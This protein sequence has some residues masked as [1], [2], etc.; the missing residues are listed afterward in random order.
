MSKQWSRHG[1]TRFN[2]YAS[3]YALIPAKWRENERWIEVSNN[4]FIESLIPRSA[5]RVGI[6]VHR[7]EMLGYGLARTQDGKWYRVAFSPD[8]RMPCLSL[9]DVADLSSIDKRFLTKEAVAILDEYFLAKECN[10]I[11]RLYRAAKKR[12]LARIQ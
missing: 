11:R 5:W 10:K 8:V 3:S 4:D 7:D 12:T 1:L 2:Y 6:Y 9:K